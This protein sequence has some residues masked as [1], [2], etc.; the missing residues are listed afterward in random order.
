MI[1]PARLIAKIESSVDPFGLIIIFSGV[2]LLAS[3]FLGFDLALAALFKY[4][5]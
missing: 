5:S 3:L 2:G 1:T 4:L